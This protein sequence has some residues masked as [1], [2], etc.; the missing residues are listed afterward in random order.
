M[1]LKPW[2]EKRD[3]IDDRI[4]LELGRTLRKMPSVGQ[5]PFLLSKQTGNF[6]S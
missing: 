4:D 3:E 6:P 2:K 5:L 1:V